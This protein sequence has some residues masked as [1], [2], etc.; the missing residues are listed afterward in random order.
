MR[1]PKKIPSKYH[2]GLT[3]HYCDQPTELADSRE[4]YGRSYGMI[5]ICRPCNAYVGTHKRS[6]K[7]YG[8]VANR[9][10]RKAKSDVHKVFDRIWMERHINRIYPEVLKNTKNREK[11]YIWLSKQMGMTR[12]TCHIGMFSVDQCRQAIR[13][14]KEA[15]IKIGEL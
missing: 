14:C 4:V 5:Y 9:E 6:G 3:C 13:I 15:L 11:A 12:A 7:A 2:D 8:V 10:L 1:K